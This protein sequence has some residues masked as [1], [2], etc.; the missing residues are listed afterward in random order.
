MQKIKDERLILK[1]LKNMRIAY[2]IQTIGIIGILGYDLVTKGMSGMTEN[3]LWFLFI[4]TAIISAYLSMNISVEH[5]NEKGSPKKGLN[6]SLFLLVII[7]IAVGII[8]SLTDE[9]NLRNGL[10]F[11]GI[12][13]VCGFI[14]IYYIYHLRRNRNDDSE[15]K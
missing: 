10:I 12:L 5:E 8:G 13:F 1:N 15:D 7:C 14:P 9:F 3:P 6:I 2:G 11:P 4:V